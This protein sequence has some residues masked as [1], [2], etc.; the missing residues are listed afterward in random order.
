M[1]IS[2]IRSRL[3]CLS[4]LIVAS[5]IAATSAQQSSSP[6][7]GKKSPIVKAAEPFPDETVLAARRADA[8]ARRLFAD[9]APLDFTLTADFR[10]INRDR[11]PES[12]RR[13]AAVLS[14]GGDRDLDVKLGTRGHFRLMARNC[15]FVP[16]RVEF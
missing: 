4:L 2:C 5:A 3:A 15:D 9:R 1:T 13:F 10:T 7:P 11:T 12:S 16:L 14:A 8:D 6:S